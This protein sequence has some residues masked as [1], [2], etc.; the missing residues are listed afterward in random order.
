MSR[1]RNCAGCFFQVE[2]CHRTS[3]G[4]RHLALLFIWW[5][6]NENLDRPISSTL[7]FLISFFSRRRFRVMNIRLCQ[8]GRRRAAVLS[9]SHQT[10]LWKYLWTI[11]YRNTLPIY[12]YLSRNTLSPP[13]D[14]VVKHCHFTLWKYEWVGENLYNLKKNIWETPKP[15]RVLL[16]TTLH[17]YT[18]TSVP[19]PF[20][21]THF[22]KRKHQNTLIRLVNSVF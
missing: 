9:P 18:T 11:L 7:H 16:I 12:K 20:D 13:P 5:K 8:G 1:V 22:L 3:S 10:W 14:I 15:Q 6:L 17:Q 19:N 2:I 21:W 4:R